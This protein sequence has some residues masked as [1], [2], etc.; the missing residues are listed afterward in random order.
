MSECTDVCV[1]VCMCVC[2][3]FYILIVFFCKHLNVYKMHSAHLK[4]RTIMEE[5]GLLFPEKVS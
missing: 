1:C 3:Y 2:L 4:K 5:V